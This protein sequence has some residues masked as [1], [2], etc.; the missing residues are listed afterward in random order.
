MHKQNA[1]VQQLQIASVF[2][3]RRN[4]VRRHVDAV[5]V[6]FAAI[7]KSVFVLR[8]RVFLRPNLSA[9]FRNNRKSAGQRGASVCRPAEATLLGM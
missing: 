8:A 9:V 5:Q 3:K 1:A 6:L 7:H 4:K 2:H